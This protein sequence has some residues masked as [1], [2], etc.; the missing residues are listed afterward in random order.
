MKEKHILDG[1]VFFNLNCFQG[2]DSLNEFFI[3]DKFMK[4]LEDKIKR[5]KVER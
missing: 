2:M 4:I 5:R 3:V 1:S